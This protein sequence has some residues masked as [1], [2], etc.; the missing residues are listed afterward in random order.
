MPYL[1]CINRRMHY[2]Y[3]TMRLSFDCDG[4]FSGSRQRIPLY[5]II[6]L[7]AINLEY[8]CLHLTVEIDREI[9]VK[10]GR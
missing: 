5:R 8:L 3:V 6:L 1:V 10:N 9:Q 7:S 4:N 2:V